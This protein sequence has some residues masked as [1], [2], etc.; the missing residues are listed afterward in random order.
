MRRQPKG[1]K[2]PDYPVVSRS[3]YREILLARMAGGDLYASEKLRKIRM[4]DRSLDALRE[5]PIYT[6]II[7][8]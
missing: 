5:K 1:K 6:T 3:E 2:S 8:E 7:K 4:I